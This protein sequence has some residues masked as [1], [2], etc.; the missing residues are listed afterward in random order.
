MG[1][2]R[3]I[4]YTGLSGKLCIISTLIRRKGLT[5]LY[6]SADRTRT[7]VVGLVCVLELSGAIITES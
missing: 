3:G 7:I 2:L 6:Q 1:H 5:S 4:G